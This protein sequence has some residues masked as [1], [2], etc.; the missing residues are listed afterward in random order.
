MSVRVDQL[1]AG[2]AEG[3]AISSE[4]RVM[5]DLLGSL[6]IESR[7]Y[8]PEER[9]APQVR[10][11]CL[12]LERYAGASRDAVLLHFS[13]DSPVNAAFC[14]SPEPKVLRY[15]NITPASFYRGFDDR[16]A[17]QLEAARAALPGVCGRAD[18][19]VAD[20]A[21]NAAE[22]R[23][24][25]GP[26]VEV[27]PLLFEPARRSEPDTAMQAL[28]PR[29]ALN[30]LY[31]GRIAPNKRIEELILMF[32]RFQQIEPRSRLLIVGSQFSCPRYYALLRLLAG[33]LDLPNVCFTGFVT[34]AQKAACYAVADAFVTASEHEGF[35][36]PL[37]EAMQYDTPV[38]ARRQ[39][40]MPEAM[41]SSGVLFEACT[42]AELAELLHETL[43]NGALREELLTAQRQ[44]LAEISGLDLAGEMTQLLAAVGVG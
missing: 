23:L 31:V 33:R 18:R 39:G 30:L 11:E 28:F 4:A 21:Y 20:S 36:L 15:H 5:R 2:Y 17:D 19:I 29:D 41:G 16:V 12:S 43:T 7:I 27:L 8:A 37:L 24:P 10:E 9:I 6:G 38:V 34:D 26:P 3:D 1:L 44:R 25:D 40:G 35:C 14:A 42:P 13:I 22:V 32:A